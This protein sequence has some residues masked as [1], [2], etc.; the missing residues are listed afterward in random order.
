[1]DGGEAKVSTTNFT[2]K[3]SYKLCD[4]KFD[5]CYFNDI[6]NKFGF[7]FFFFSAWLMIHG[8]TQLV[9]SISCLY[10]IKKKKNHC[11]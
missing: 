4:N 9:V 3:K 1:M 6:I 8:I 7:L 2:I 11:L 10:G 5:W